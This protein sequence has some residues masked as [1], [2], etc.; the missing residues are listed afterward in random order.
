VKF[1]AMEV[2]SEGA[3]TEDFA[4]HLKE[5]ARSLWDLQQAGV[6]REAYFRADRRTA[7]LV[8]ECEG[9]DQAEAAL[10]GLPLARRGLIRFDLV[11]LLPYSGYA[12]LFE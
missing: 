4:P 7:V 8:L 1:L 11:P 9:R 3:R 2:E 5:E 6:V 10:G 12:R